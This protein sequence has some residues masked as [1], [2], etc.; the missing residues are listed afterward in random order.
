MP[1][2]ELPLQVI[3]AASL[4]V[5]MIAVLYSSVGHGGASGYLAVLAFLAIRPSQMATTALLL[6]IIVA[7]VAGA[8][9]VRAGHLS[10]TLTWPFVVTSVPAA[11]A[12]GLAPVT[13][14]VYF[15]M[16]AATLM[17]A[18]VRLALSLKAQG[19]ESY[20]PPPL[21]FSLPAGAAIGLLSGVVG[22]GGGVFLSP[23]M[24]LARWA[25]AK[26]T[27]ATSA[28]FII[29]NS[30]AGLGGRA[31]RGDGDIGPLAPL[32][33]AGLVGSL[34][35]SSL[36]ANTFSGATLRRILA[37]VLVAAASKLILSLW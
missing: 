13:E 6:N 28:C 4:L 22:V 26:R 7:G 27:A 1:P 35:G 14:R 16:L 11:F 9:F 25:D 20:R 33:A 12:G 23:L 24:I 31:L 21:L 18:A 36:G 2:S 15:A 30:L 3:A 34:V 10:P 29:V 5:F 19:A 32:L 37:V 8:V 17:A